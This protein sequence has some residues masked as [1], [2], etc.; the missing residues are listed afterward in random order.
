MN[1]RNFLKYFL[2]KDTTFKGEFRA[3]QKLL[4]QDCPRIIVDVGAHN[5]FY[6]SNSYPYV[7]RGWRAVLIEPPG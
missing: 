1:L 5:G 2:F 6:A 3:M 7:A 4:G